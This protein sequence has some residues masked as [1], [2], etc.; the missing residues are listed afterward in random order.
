MLSRN[1]TLF[2]SL[3][4]PSS[5]LIGAAALP[6]TV[7][8][9][10]PRASAVSAG[11]SA[12]QTAFTHDI[13][14]MVKTFCVSCHSGKSPA[15][16][17]SL[18]KYRTVADA[19][20]DQ[21][22]WE[23]VSSNVSSRHM[24]PMDALQPTPAER[25]KLAT[26]V[27]TTLSN[28][29][30][31]VHDPGH[32]TLRRLNREEY[33]NTIR[34]LVGM[35]LRPA[36]DF[37]SDDSGYGFDNIGD[38]LSLSPLLMEKFLSAAEKI[39]TAV[40]VTPESTG[41]PIHFDSSIVAKAGNGV[42][43][44]N[45]AWML[46]TNG[47]ISLDVN[48]P[49]DGKYLLRARAYGDQAGPDPA[50]MQI[51]LDGKILETDDVKAV[52][53]NSKVYETPVQSSAG[54]HKVSF[55]FTN[56]YYDKD[57]PDPKHRDRN[58]IV[59]AADIVPPQR[60]PSNLP[61][62]HRRILF[63]SPGPSNED[64][65]AHKILSEFA[66]RAYRRPVTSAEV[67]RLVGYVHEAKKEGESFE[68]G[69]QVAV[70]AVL[71]SPNF[72]FHV[73]TDPPQPGGSSKRPLNDY[74]LASRLSYF[75]WNSMPDEGLFALAA[76]G[77]LKNPQMLATQVH[78]MLK[79]PKA[80][81]FAQNFAGQWL[82]LRN[83][84]LV[85]PDPARYPD[86]NEALRTAM[87]TETEMFFQA[88]VKEDRPI[89]EFLDAKFTF[90]NEPLAKHYGISGVSGNAFRRVTLTD[91]HRGGLLTQASILTIT[92]NPT[93]TSP[94]KRGKWVLE[95]ILGTP[96]PPPP[97]GVGQLPDEKK[98]ALTGT[99]RQRMEQHRKN[100]ICASCHLAMDPIGF[101]LENFD[102]VGAWRTQDGNL[103]VN[104]AGTL[105]GNLNF[106]GPAE[107]KAILKA[108]Q[109]LFVHCL[110]TKVMT[111]ALGRGILPTDKCNIDNI[112]STVTRDDYHF[113]S[114]ITAVVQSDPFRKRRGEGGS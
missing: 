48:F 80:Y 64:A 30:C 17:I 25:E 16:G 94:V 6:N 70:E 12:S 55:A 111:Y 63:V 77:T 11:A 75:L 104:A 96:P 46:G 15:A 72:L 87:K 114:L 36:D 69:I 105:P 59:E 19:L 67:D 21:S 68:R 33:N 99:L 103:P 100:P 76:K 113:S 1:T 74:E 9:H 90:L 8:S 91:P 42:P 26:W 49:T 84:S 61:A 32:V 27:D 35:D 29:Q 101:G 28:A 79:D 34:D 3:L 45:K 83:L 41:K 44:G 37:P 93:R 110:A 71:V 73:E 5:L 97:P 57:F 13:I 78:R 20:K 58:L 51:R 7:R 95:Q 109:K 108:K 14:P 31:Q 53:G 82:Q 39:A 98:A 54:P 60:L 86:F 43:F 66:R 23:K 40:I 50:R 62:S 89:P 56:D 22:I 4:A 47:E 24:P 2:L 88:M 106:N 18:A 52:Q 107:L 92:S 10:R 38:V 112:V 65:C 85:A 81:A 102:A